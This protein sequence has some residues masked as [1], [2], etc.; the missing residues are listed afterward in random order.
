M[1]V[2]THVAL[3]VHFRYRVPYVSRPFRGWWQALLYCVV[4]TSF[5]RKIG[6]ILC[7]FS[8]TL[9]HPLSNRPHTLHIP[10]SPALTILFYGVR[11]L[12]VRKKTFSGPIRLTKIETRKVAYSSWDWDFRHMESMYVQSRVDIIIRSQA[13]SG[14]TLDDIIATVDV[15]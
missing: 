4:N 12:R 5:S 8:R 7:H 3:I 15:R 11:L 2:N 13:K 6:F 14:A 9:E 10:F 1:T